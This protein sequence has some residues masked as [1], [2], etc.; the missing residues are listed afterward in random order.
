MTTGWRVAAPYILHSGV[1]VPPMG[2]FTGAVP[3]PTG[4]E[5]RRLIDTGRL[6]FVVLGGPATAP[7]RSLAPWVRDHC[8][9]VPHQAPALYRCSPSPAASHAARGR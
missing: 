6:R 9:P 2:G 7:G 5:F 1:K 4:S 3:S 8:A